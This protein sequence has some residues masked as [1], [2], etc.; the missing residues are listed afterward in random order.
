MAQDEWSAIE[1]SAEGNPTRADVRQMVCSMLEE[2][3]QFTGHLE[4]RDVLEVATPGLG[5]KPHP[6]G[7]PFTISSLMDE[8][9][10][11]QAYPTYKG[12][13]LRCGVFNRELSH[14][15]ERPLEMLD[16]TMQQIADSLGAATACHRRYWAQGT[17]RCGARL[18]TGQSSGELRSFRRAW[19]SS[20]AGCY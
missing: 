19:T 5:L 2:R 13:H 1:A 17:L 6:E 18:W 16:V 7:T 15:G 9:K 3:L 11:P 8:N 12:F 20:V 14:I 10:Y 4:K